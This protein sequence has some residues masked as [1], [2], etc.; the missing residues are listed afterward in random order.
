MKSITEIIEMSE[1]KNHVFEAAMNTFA[2]NPED[3]PSMYYDSFTEAPIIY[4][5]K[6]SKNLHS[7]KDE[8]RI[9]EIPAFLDSLTNLDKKLYESMMSIYNDFIKTANEFDYDV[10]HA[11]FKPFEAYGAANYSE[12]WANQEFKEQFDKDR[13]TIASRLRPI[14]QAISNI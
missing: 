1:Y 14:N 10:N 12:M 9:M 7:T 2:C 6:N 4:H 11:K 8:V 5:L 3:G 13:N